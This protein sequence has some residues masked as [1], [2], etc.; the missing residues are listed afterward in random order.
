MTIHIS[1]AKLKYTCLSEGYRYSYRD[2]MDEFVTL[3]YFRGVLHL[4]QQ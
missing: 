2:L 1:L 4:A 3:D